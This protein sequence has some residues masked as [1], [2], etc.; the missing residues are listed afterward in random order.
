MY[1]SSTRIRLLIFPEIILHTLKQGSPIS[2]IPLCIRVSLTKTQLAASRFGTVKV[3][4]VYVASRSIFLSNAF[5]TSFSHIVRIS[6][7]ATVICFF[8][9]RASGGICGNEITNSI[10]KA[11]YIVSLKYSRDDP[12]QAKI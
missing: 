10:Q 11:V 4:Y 9:E 1:F 7:P 3:L 5:P 8:K 6:L 12:Y 2:S